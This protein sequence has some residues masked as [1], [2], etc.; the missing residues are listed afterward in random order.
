MVT[1][2]P[3]RRRSPESA[4][5]DLDVGLVDSDSIEVRMVLNHVAAVAAAPNLESL[6]VGGRT[7]ERRVAAQSTARPRFDQA[8]DRV[9]HLRRGDRLAL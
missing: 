5:Q 6:D 9:R 1:P 3:P 4:P 7:T 2:W 8:P